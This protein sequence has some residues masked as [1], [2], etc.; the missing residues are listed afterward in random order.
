ME[1]SSK[2]RESSSRIGILRNRGLCEP[3]R[4]AHH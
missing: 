1:F 3:W 2:V 4:S